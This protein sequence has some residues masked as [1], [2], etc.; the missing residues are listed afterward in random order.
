MKYH[1]S[2]DQKDR[3]SLPEV[4]PVVGELSDCRIVEVTDGQLDEVRA[5]LLKET[6]SAEYKLR[7]IGEDHR[8]YVLT[9]DRVV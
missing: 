2:I 9:A 5:I 8:R 6:G 7:L 1:I 3:I 4:F